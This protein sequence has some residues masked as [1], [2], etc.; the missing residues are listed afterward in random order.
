M[1]NFKP[2][3]DYLLIRHID[4][5][6]VRNGIELPNDKASDTRPQ[7]AEV[8]AIGPGRVSEYGAHIPMPPVEVGDIVL[9]QH[10]AGVRFQRDG[11]EHRLVTAPTVLALVPRDAV[12]R[13]TLTPLH[14]L[15]SL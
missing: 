2:T 14:D 1:I 6:D 15:R 9:I 10:A 4:R 13:D 5:P 3:Q 7:F 11:E 8:L 12:G